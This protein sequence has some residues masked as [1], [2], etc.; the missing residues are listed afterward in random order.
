MESLKGNS[1]SPQNMHTVRYKLFRMHSYQ[2][3][4]VYA[5]LPVKYFVYSQVFIQSNGQKTV[6]GYS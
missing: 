5:N 2:K 1:V 6:I 3:V 4:I